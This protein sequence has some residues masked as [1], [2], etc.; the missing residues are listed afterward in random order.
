MKKRMIALIAFVAVALVSCNPTGSSSYSLTVNFGFIPAVNL[1]DT[2]YLDPSVN[3]AKY[4]MD[5]ILFNYL[6]R[7]KVAG[8]AS[9]SATG[10]DIYTIDSLLSK[11]ID[12]TYKA[13]LP[14]AKLYNYKQLLE[15]K[16]A[17][18]AGEIEI[19]YA[20]LNLDGQ[21]GEYNKAEKIDAVKFETINKRYR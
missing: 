14:R 12:S 18:F 2:T 16:V 20:T 21:E 15:D 7:D 11:Q 19:V 9:F 1:V 10:P 4:R 5:T 17:F 3:N 6:N 8:V 13:L